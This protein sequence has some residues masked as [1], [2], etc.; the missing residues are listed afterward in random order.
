[1]ACAFH[2]RFKYGTGQKENDETMTNFMKSS[3]HGGTSRVWSP[4]ERLSKSY[5]T[6]EGISNMKHLQKENGKQNIDCY[7]L[8]D[9]SR[10]LQNNFANI[11][12]DA[13]VPN[14]KLLSFFW[15]GLIHS[16]WLITK[17][18][19]QSRHVENKEDD[20]ALSE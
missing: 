1:M 19:H 12:C 3:R 17:N 6:F 16:P 5:I 9:F 10:V 18:V 20:G 8:T 7:N 15:H 11:W 14:L 13:N 2:L 4:L